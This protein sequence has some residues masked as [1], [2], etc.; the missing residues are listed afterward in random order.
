MAHWDFDEHKWRFEGKSADNVIN[1]G[2]GGNGY[3]AN[4]AHAIA[5]AHA[6]EGLVPD[7][8]IEE[9]KEA[10]RKVVVDFRPSMAKFKMLF[11]SAILHVNNALF[12]KGHPPAEYGLE[13]YAVNL[14]FFINRTALFTWHR[15]ELHNSAT[16]VLTAVLQLTGDKT[17][18][19]VAGAAQE[20]EYEG[21][22]SLIAFPSAAYHRSGTGTTH[23][24]K[25][26]S[27]YKAAKNAA[28]RTPPGNASSAQ[29]SSQEE[30]EDEHSGGLVDDGEEGTGNGEEPGGSV[31]EVAAAAEEGVDP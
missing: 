13:L 24:V 16:A 26:T 25:L 3:S 10:Q 19:K 12:G 21:F 4:V 11:G 27:L 5:K 7:F 1:G 9:L 14:L 8:Q 2:W 23:T 17:S 29:P 22:G 28:I 18:M 6:P 20:A 15:D 31:D 30:E